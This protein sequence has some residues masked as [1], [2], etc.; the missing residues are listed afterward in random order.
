MTTAIAALAAIAIILGVYNRQPLDKW[1]HSIKLN[2][3]LS[4][5]ATIMKGFLLMPVCACLS[6]LKW[7]WYTRQAKSLEDFQ[8]FDVASRGPW[9]AVQL[10]FR[11]DFWHMASLGSLVTL[12][13][14]AS[15]AFVQQSVSYPL[16]IDPQGDNTAGIPYAQSFDSYNTAPDGAPYASQPLMAA[17]Y[18][19]VFSK[20]LTRSTSS[21][22]P[23]CSTGNC[24]F[25]SYA[26]L[27]VCS[28]CHNVTS[29]LRF[30]TEPNPLGSI[31]N[32]TLPNG[33]SLISAETSI[34]Y[35]NISASSG[36]STLPSNPLH[37]NSDVLSAYQSAGTITNI[38]VVTGIDPSRPW[39]QTAWDCVL[40]FC[41]KSYNATESL[42]FFDETLL[43]VFDELKSTILPVD[44]P[45]Y[46]ETITFNVPS[47][48]LTTIGNRN[49]TFFIKTTALQALQDSLG[50]TLVGKSEQNAVGQFEFSS[51][52]AQGFYY[53]GVENVVMT[54]NNIADALT[55]AMRMS[56]GHYVQGSA[57]V[58]KV[59]IHVQWWWLILPLVMVILGAIFLS[60]TVW[61]TQRS[62]VPSWR[63]SVLA[64]MQHGANTHVHEGSGGVRLSGSD[65]GMVATVGEEKVSDL[66]VWAEG[67]WVRLRR[68]GLLGKSFGLTVT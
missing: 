45:I 60:L 41:A 7:L 35:L 63:S 65:G 24:T 19:G 61:Q 37:L 32:Y 4:T 3:V 16:R 68:R 11:L 40:S 44:K 23:Y 62:G 20:N 29:S 14:L 47:T 22:T 49:R 67:V 2:T 46:A 53:N 28:K 31:Y 50:E 38:S 1:P 51:G 17:V 36:P 66:E 34:A 26:S 39:T 56:S 57:R 5:L 10:L 15:D 21:I 18:D 27:G 9:G 12:L 25:P 33:H 42:N 52:I 6:Q 30:T 59:H 48:H 8:I 54:V 58:M 64:V 43:E 13:S 55:D